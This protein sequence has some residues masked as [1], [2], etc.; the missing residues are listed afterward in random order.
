[1]RPHPSVAASLLA[2]TACHPTTTDETATPGTEVPGAVCPPPLTAPTTDRPGTVVL[3][4]IDTLNVSF[5]DEN[6]SNWVV[7]PNIDALLAR[8]VEF[9]HT[10]VTRGMSQPSLASYLTGAYPRT[11]GIRTND[12][13]L[14]IAADVPTLFQRF[15]EAGYYTAAFSANMCQLADTTA[16]QILCTADGGGQRLS[17]EEADA[18]LVGGLTNLLEAKDP[19]EPLF[20]WIHFMDPHDPYDQREPWYSTFHPDTYTGPFVDITQE[21]LES[22]TMGEITLTDED[23]RHIDATYASQIAEDDDRV[24]Q[25]LA[26]LDKHGR[27]DATIAFGPDHGEEL[28]H[29][30]TYFYHG[31]SPYNL[32]TGVTTGIVSPGRIT[33][34]EV[35]DSWVSSTNIAPTLVELA[36]LS[37][38][39]AGEGTSLMDVVDRCVEPEEDVFLERGTETAAIIRGQMKYIF[40]PAEGDPDCSYKLT[41]YAYP[42]TLRSLYDLAADPDERENLADVEP[43]TELDLRKALCNWVN[44]GVW[45][46]SGTVTDNRLEARCA[47]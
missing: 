34:G 40:D 38:S 9:R 29:R 18:A 4:T 21:L 43:D 17:Q 37:W 7:T 10:S 28:A 32:V 3:L 8:G 35:L 44:A 20:V 11:H 30:G 15:G 36:G 2:F 5:L 26:L 45:D 31:C 19:A 12:D 13:T 27:G 33:A 16:D 22:A 1:M 39:G 24:G 6:Q 46:A 14:T 42:G 23:R 47:R 41:H 25:I